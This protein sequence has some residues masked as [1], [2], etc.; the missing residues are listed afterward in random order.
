M[1]SKKSKNETNT[2]QNPFDEPINNTGT[3]QYDT[4]IG[5]EMEEEEVYLGPLE[6]KDKFRAESLIKRITEDLEELKQI[7]EID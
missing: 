7:L 3:V 6:L 5:F 2:K 1:S 4:D